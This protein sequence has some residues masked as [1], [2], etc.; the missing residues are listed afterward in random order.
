MLLSG[1]EFE[2]QEVRELEF[3]HSTVGLLP[4]GGINLK[5]SAKKWQNFCNDNLMFSQKGI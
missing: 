2:A 1:F 4:K 5:V 3:D